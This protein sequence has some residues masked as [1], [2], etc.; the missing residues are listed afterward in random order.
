[1]SFVRAVWATIT[2][3]RIGF[4]LAVG[5]AVGL[6]R[7]IGLWQAGAPLGFAPVPLLGMPL[8][9]LYVLVATLSAD[10]AVARGARRWPA[11]GAAFLVAILVSAATVLWQ[12]R[13][14]GVLPQATPLQGELIFMAQVALDVGFISG[15]AVL[16]Y[17]NRR[18]ANQILQRVHDAELQRVQLER[19]LIESRLATAEAQVD[20]Q[21]LFGA[22][23]EIRD[24]FERASP[25]ADGKLET[26]IQRLR[27]ALARTVVAEDPNAAKP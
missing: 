13:S 20:P 11:Y 15:L 1:M 2:W 12:A 16:A 14:W 8:A 24:E 18:A 17:A 6:L 27:V 5:L 3:R 9:A 22:L 10:E 25:A 4:A 23:T 21:M 7:S 19:R 26:L